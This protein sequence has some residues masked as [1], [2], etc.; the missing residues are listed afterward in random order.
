MYLVQLGFLSKNLIIK[1]PESVLRQEGGFLRL[2]PSD[3]D[4]VRISSLH[5]VPG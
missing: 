2:L 3:P 5:E 4:L 1:K